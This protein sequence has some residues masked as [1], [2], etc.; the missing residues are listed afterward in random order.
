[1]VVLSVEWQAEALGELCGHSRRWQNPVPWQERLELAL[2]L[3]LVFDLTCTS[4]FIMLKLDNV[5]ARRYSY[6][7][8]RH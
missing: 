5:S 8:S 4:V 6:L 1:M 7:H 3:E 2:H